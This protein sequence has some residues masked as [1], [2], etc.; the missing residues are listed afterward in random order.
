MTPSP[1]DQL[2]RYIVFIRVSGEMRESSIFRFRNRFES[3][4]REGMEDMN[5]RIP[6]QFYE[7]KV[8]GKCW[9]VGSPKLPQDNTPQVPTFPPALDWLP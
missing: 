6:G 3:I 1:Q 8:Q 9:M 4:V 7:W 5:A 2:F